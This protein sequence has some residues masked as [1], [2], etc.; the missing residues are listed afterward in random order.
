MI[1]AFAIGAIAF[2][3]ALR[4]VEAE[5]ENHVFT[6]RADRIRLVV[7]R[8]WRESDAPSYPGMLLWLMRPDTKIVL[9]AEPFTRALYCSWP[10]TCRTSHEVKT[11][12]AKLACALRQKL[13]DA[14]MHIGAIQEGPKENEAAG[15]ASVWFD[16]DDGKHFMRQAVALGEDRAF[17]LVMESSSAEVRN[18]QIR[19]FEQTLRT[20]RP[21][22]EAEL[23]APPA[24]GTSLAAPGNDAGVAAAVVVGDGGTIASATGSAA[25]ALGSGAGSGAPSPAPY[26]SA[27]AAKINP[28]GSCTK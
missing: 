21:L 15:L 24:P 25:A 16:Y 10:I 2:V 22:T 18:S 26:P 1:T 7:P 5:L 11:V 12:E 9:T 13:V 23:G 8:G 6:S 4:P 27:P 3:T 28:I 20:L 19:A 17:S 14:G